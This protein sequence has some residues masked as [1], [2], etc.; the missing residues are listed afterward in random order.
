MVMVEISSKGQPVS[1]SAVPAFTL[2]AAKLAQ[3]YENSASLVTS[4]WQQKTASKAT[5]RGAKR[6]G[7]AGR[8][9]KFAAGTEAIHCLGITTEWPPGMRAMQKA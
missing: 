1:C 8:L 9:G 7:P 2:A 3:Y 6:R 5:A 4:L